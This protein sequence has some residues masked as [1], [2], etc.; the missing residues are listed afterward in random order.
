MRFCPEALRRIHKLLRKDA[1]GV[2]AVE[3]ALTFPV[4]LALI[5]GLFEAGRLFSTQHAL[6]RGVAA[7]ARW[8]AVNSGT[9]SNAI[10]TQFQNALMPVLGS[11][12]QSCTTTS[13]AICTFTVSPAS[14]AGD[15]ITVTAAYKWSPL[16]GMTFAAI[17]LSSTISLTAQN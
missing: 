15:T 8:A 10:L 3:F 5:L 6:N 9:T 2:A 4:V 11:T 7:A 13:G 17:T 14:K 1:R 12:A 16:T